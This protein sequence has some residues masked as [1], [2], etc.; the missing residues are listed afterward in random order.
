ML[1]E[2]EALP[3]VLGRM[4]DG[5]EP[6]V[7]DNG[8]TDGS[9]EL[10]ERLGAKVIHEPRPGFGAACYA[11]LAGASSRDRLLHGLRRLAGSGRAAARGRPVAAGNAD[12][13]LGARQAAPGGAGPLHARVANRLLALELRRRTGAP[14]HDLGP[15]RA[16]RREPLLALGIRDRRF[17]WPLEMVLRASAA[18]W[19][20]DEVGVSALPARG[21]LEG[22]RHGARHGPRDARHGAGALVNRAAASHAQPTMDVALLVIAKAPVP[23]RVKTRLSPPCTPGQAAALAQRRAGGHARGGG[24]VPAHRA[25]GG[26]PRRRAGPVAA[27]RLRGDPPARGRARGALRGRVRGRGRA[28]RCWS[29]WTRPS[30]PPGLLDAGL[31]ALTADGVDA[32]LGTALDGGYWA[33]GLRTADPHVFRNVPM[34]VETTGAMQA[35]RLAALGL[36]TVALP[37]LLDVDTVADARR[38]AAEAPGSRFAATFAA[39]AP[40]LVTAA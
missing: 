26:R 7:V 12:L 15:M 11:G 25:A 20:I 36:A 21:P 2:R 33:I 35:A 4:P 23:G 14:L 24:R 27:R 34:S 5:Y 9:G 30:S 6:I 17:G 3:W 1:D 16:A 37:P 8:S 38:V 18:G 31:E 40:D 19:R 10:A 39:I 28:L 29:A 32:V 22:D 13:V